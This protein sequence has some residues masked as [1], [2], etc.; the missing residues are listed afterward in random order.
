[1][2]VAVTY[3][4]K[5]GLEK[6]FAE[7]GGRQFSGE[8]EP[9]PTDFFAEGDSSATIDS[10]LQA[11]SSLGHDLRGYEADAD[12]CS[13]LRCD[14]PQLVFNMAE[15]L[16]GASRE[17]YV[18]TLCEKLCIPYTGSDP[19]VLAVCL[20]KAK[21][22]ELL[23]FHGIATPKFV[24]VSE[25]MSLSALKKL[26]FPAIVK[27]NCEGSSKG[28][29]NDSVVKDFESLRAKIENNFRQYSQAAIVEELILGREFTVATIG[30]GDGMEILPP[31]E[32]CHSELPSGAWPIYS[33]EAKWIWDRPEKP[34][35]IF[36]C[37]AKLSKPLK[38]KI[39]KL[40]RRTVSAMGIRD[41]CRTDIRLDSEGNP[42]V[43][44]IN[45]LPGILPN[46]EDNSC[47]PKAARSAGYSYPQMLGK[48]ID[49]AARRNGI[50]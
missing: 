15:G 31:V 24:L 40:I 46:P 3:S 49:C 17:S 14:P 11:I 27:P 39:E 50:K 10:V 2:K 30:N 43:I 16:F 26:R 6:E 8:D 32:I 38:A 41:W 21:C 23:S 48:I 35:K 44:E 13:R 12:L 36:D 9:P 22:K 1:L 34:L 29:F 47:F 20:N 5:E 42:Q 28:V 18:P 37:P 33:Y 19:L 25:E 45:P 4:T 7:F